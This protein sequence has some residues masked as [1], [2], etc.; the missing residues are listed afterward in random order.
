M[1]SKNAD[2]ARP[3]ARRRQ[4]GLPWTSRTSGA[5]SGCAE[6]SG[7]SP[8]SAPAADVSRGS[9]HKS[10]CSR[11]HQ[12]NSPSLLTTLAFQRFRQILEWWQSHNP[13][14][15][16]WHQGET[17]T[18][19]KAPEGAVREE[20]AQALRSNGGNLGRAFV[21]FQ[22]GFT[23]NT[24]LVTGGAAANSGAAGNLRATIHAIMDRVI[25]N[26]PT[27]AILAGRSVG[28][29]LRDNPGLSASA[30]AYLADLRTDLDATAED[31]AAI[32]REDQI[33]EQGSKE[34]E[35]ALEESPG[36]YVYTLLS[37]YRTPQKSDPVR[38]W[39][40]IGKTDRS[41]GVRVG[42]LMRMTGL[43]EDPWIARVYRHSSIT[44][45]ELEARIHTLLD[46]AGHGR[47]VGKHAGREW[48]ATNLEFLDAVATALGCE[49]LQQALPE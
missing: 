42:E 27:V 1:A 17:V 25:P 5:L 41:A 3:K 18:T 15:E 14:V 32:D 34:L 49:I 16:S 39:F 20:L 7:A 33:L 4:S 8:I 11:L 28:G 10:V 37:F 23:S 31:S 6:P 44:P 46:A 19:N 45:I 9:D 13:V 22:Q 26:G 47:A 38:Y 2:C 12:G 24:E 40:K 35:E 21:L 36:V 48:Y 43:P 29:L 30:K